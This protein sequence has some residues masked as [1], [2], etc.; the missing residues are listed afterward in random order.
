MLKIQL[1]AISKHFL[2]AK[3]F[4]RASY[5]KCFGL[6]ADIFLKISDKLIS[7]LVR[8]QF[9]EFGDAEFGGFYPV[10]T[11]I[12]FPL[13]FG[14]IK[15]AAVFTKLAPTAFVRLF[16]DF[17]LVTETITLRSAFAAN[18]NALFRF[19]LAERNCG[20]RNKPN[21]DCWQT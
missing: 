19:W 9:F 10:I 13:G 3:R 17:D 14:E 11:G 20:S 18:R 12:S 1:L 4:L 8:F 2:P 5:L 7:I 21:Y 16:R 15:F 6:F